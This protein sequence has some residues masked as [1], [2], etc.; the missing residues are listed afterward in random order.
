MHSATSQRLA[1]MLIGAGVV[2]PEDCE[3]ALQH[4]GSEPLGRR[5][6]ALG[7]ASEEQI[8]EALARE[9][10]LPFVR[11]AS[12]TA[13]SQACEL[14]PEPLA[15]RYTVLPVEVRGR[16]LALAMADPLNLDAIKD[17]EFRSRLSVRPVV[18]TASEIQDAIVRCYGTAERLAPFIRDLH[19]TPAAGG[20]AT[21]FLIGDEIVDVRK[22]DE[23]LPVVRM[24]NLLISEGI[25]AGASDIH[26]E[27][28]VG[29]VAV[30]NRI[31]G[32]LREALTVPRWIHAKLVSRL[33]ILANLDIAERRRPQD[34]RMKVQH[35]ER[36]L[37]LRV[38]VLPT[39]CG[40]KVVLRLLDSSRDVL[41]LPHL[42][43][44]PDQMAIL[45]EAL[46][47]PQGTILVTGPTGS[48]KTSTLYAA[49]SRLKSPGVNVVTLENPIEFQIKGVNQVQVHERAGLTFASSLRSILR[50]DPD[51]IMV[52]EIRDSETAETAFQAALTGHLV[53]STLHTNSAAS[54]ITRLLDLAV[55]PFL[56]SSSVSLVVAQRL[57]RR[58][59]LHCREPYRPEPE[60]LAR[61]GLDDGTP[62]FRATGCDRCH[63]TGYRGRIGVF[64]LLPVGPRLSELIVQRAP[65]AALVE[66][67]T[68][69]GLLTLL[70]SAALKVRQGVTSPDEVFR[71]V[72]RDARVH[73][74]CPSCASKVE[75]SF[76]MCPSC[77][78]LL[79]PK[80]G[81]CRQDLRPEWKACPFCC[82]P[83][84]RAA[85]ASGPAA[86][87]GL[88]SGASA[89]NLQALVAS[90]LRT[91]EPASPLRLCTPRPRAD[92]T[93]AA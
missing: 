91:P 86:P 10:R 82:A 77:E 66:E 54:A 30:R 1:Q 89:R 34:G 27:P 42:G 12:L 44:E 67:A 73:H 31:D 71:V 88:A 62:V 87:A 6:V 47:Q 84:G 52:G 22:R 28:G 74:R 19:G 17:V 48:G 85:D 56:V 16:T 72:Q 50:Q 36:T 26:I 64:E 18:A 23:I 92:P 3:L 21:E 63:R 25:K 55:E 20:Q 80:C 46:T 9:L 81:A 29:E 83:I 79:R 8:A 33:K 43:L 11:L 53:L 24:V 32:V 61:L 70:E 51:V 49:V 57:V 60:V 65:E 90:T 59:C 4:D 78:T 38:S 68:A 76:A 15:E 41:D 14:V 2:R 58:L 39:H 35:G 75:A 69:Q 45:E 13:S 37:D 5:L 40:E 7:L 93:P